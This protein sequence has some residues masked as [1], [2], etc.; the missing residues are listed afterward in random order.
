MNKPKGGPEPYD[1]NPWVVGGGP[2][3]DSCSFMALRW[4]P[5]GG[6]PLWR[7]RGRAKRARGQLDIKRLLVAALIGQSAGPRPFRRSIHASAGCHAPRGTGRPPAGTV[8]EFCRQSLAP[9]GFAG[10]V[11]PRLRRHRVRPHDLCTGRQ[12]PCG[13]TVRW[14]RP[15]NRLKGHAP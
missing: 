14:A 7:E 9:T 13:V 12:P 6:D 2:P 10:N 3:W 11:G 1:D 15:P 8:A 4:Q 5:L